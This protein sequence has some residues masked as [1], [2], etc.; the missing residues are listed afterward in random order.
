MMSKEDKFRAQLTENYLSRGNTFSKEE[1]DFIDNKLGSKWWR[2]NHLYHIRDKDGKLQRM[3]LNHSQAKVLKYKHNKKIILK[4][5]Q[6]GISTLYLAYN[7]DACLFTP[8]ISVGIQSYGQDE[9]EKLSKRALLMWEMLDQEIKDL[10][11]LTLISN[12]SKGMT[13]SNGSVLKIGNFR[14]D[15]LQALHVSELAKIAKKYPEKAKELKTG[16][17]Q[18][19]SAKNKITI[20]STAEGPSGLFYEMWMKA[21]RRK[22]AGDLTPLDFEPIFLSWMEDSDCTMEQEYSMTA[23]AEEYLNDLEKELGYKP[24][25]SKQQLNWLVA[26]LEELGD[27]FN[28]EYPATADMAFAQSLEGTYY[29]HEFKALKY[30]KGTLEDGNP[31]NYN[32][33]LKVHSAIDL[34]MNDTFAI[35]FFQKYPDGHIELIGEYMNS[36]YGLEHYRDIFIS[37]SRKFGW[38]HGNTY[39]PHD[40]SVRELIADKTRWDALVE[41]GF[42]PILVRKHK[43]VDGIEATRKFLKTIRIHTSCDTTI[44]SIQSYRKKY[45]NKYNVYLD[46]P[47]HDEHSHAADAIRYLAMGDKNSPISDIYIRSISK[48][49]QY[50]RASGMDI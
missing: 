6:Q 49:T 4:S 30:A 22:E 2:L 5:R 9:A 16:A 19:V 50:R 24:Q 31:S 25:F 33:S 3:A 34:G 42:N 35:I 37:L 39:V 13:F 14:G 21:V 7:L 48:P 29:A 26:K 40:T 43:L 46:T 27:D 23:Q 47:V 20:E 41:L 1:L 28:Q 10:M 11:G 45:D 8:G 12:N 38:V 36:G 44:K 15:T 17:F 18:A 32:T